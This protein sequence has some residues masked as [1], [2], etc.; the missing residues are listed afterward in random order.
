MSQVHK[1]K[2]S[3]LFSYINSG[4]LKTTLTLTLNQTRLNYL[5]FTETFNIPVVIVLALDC[6]L[7]CS[8]PCCYGY[9]FMK[10][11]S[12]VLLTSQLYIQ[13]FTI[14]YYV[15]LFCFDQP[16]IHYSKTKCTFGY[17]LALDS[18]RC[19][20][21][22]CG[23]GYLFMKHSSSTLVR[24]G[25]RDHAEKKKSNKTCCNQNMPAPP[26]SDDLQC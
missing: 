9:L 1:S 26:L 5:S 22:A 8:S 24:T 14:P 21:L 25:P 23:C 15:V 17:V 16:L 2:K 7:C 20:S 19:C 4:K 18:S 13:L 6:P 11:S 12:P 3:A 10:H